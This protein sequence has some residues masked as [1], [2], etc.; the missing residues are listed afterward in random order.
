MFLLKAIEIFFGIVTTHND[1]P[2]YEKQILGSIYVFFTLFGYWVRGGGAPQG[3]QPS[4][5]VFHPSC[6]EM[7]V[8]QPCLFDIVATHNDHARYV[9]HILG[10]IHVFFMVTGSVC[11]LGRPWDGFWLIIW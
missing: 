8:S 5:A 7:E 2:S 6:S 1:L 10:S 4:C 3:T 11:H 9:R